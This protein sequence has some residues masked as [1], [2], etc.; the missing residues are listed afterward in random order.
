M[1]P[2]VTETSFKSIFDDTE[3]SYEFDV[4]GQSRYQ[5]ISLF[6]VLSVI[7]GLLSI[8]T[9]F[10]WLFAF[11]PVGGIVLALWAQ[12]QILRSPETTTGMR[13]AQVGFWLCIAMWVVGLIGWLYVQAREVPHGYKPLTFKMLQPDQAGPSLV[14]PTIEE[15]DGKRVYLKGYMYPGRQT[16]R[17]KKFLL[18]PTKGHCKFCMSAIPPTQIIQVELVGDLMTDYVSYAT[19]VGGRLRIDKD[20]AKGKRRGLPYRIEADYLR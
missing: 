1:V 10:S 9:A 16:I 4:A 11:I 15:L 12:Q 7:C 19:G 5:S 8:L 20:V 13:V 6:A 18:V 3:G 17:L 14:P 2:D